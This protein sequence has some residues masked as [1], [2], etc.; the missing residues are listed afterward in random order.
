MQRSIS[1]CAGYRQ[2][3][4][5][6]DISKVETDR[7]VNALPKPIALNPNQVQQIAAGTA[8]SLPDLKTGVTSGLWSPEPAI[9]GA[10][11]PYVA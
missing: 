2:E 8:A 10:S 4:E 5:E 1:R 11:L 7:D 6:R 9:P 3:V